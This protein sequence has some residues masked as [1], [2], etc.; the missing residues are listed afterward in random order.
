VT[1]DT[2]N[3][4]IIVLAEKQFA[5]SA[6]SWVNNVNDKTNQVYIKKETCVKA[7]AE[8]Y[9]LNLLGKTLPK[10]KNEIL[11]RCIR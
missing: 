8:G 5:K 11:M 9:G 7:L 6:Y 1:A 3:D 4:D 2:N 10:F